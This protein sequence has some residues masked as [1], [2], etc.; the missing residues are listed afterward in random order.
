MRGFR[1]FFYKALEDAASGNPS[2]SSRIKMEYMLGRTRFPKLEINYYR[3]NP[4]E[5]AEEYLNAVP[6]L[7]IY[8]D[9]D[10]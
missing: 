6:N 8:E 5:L 1:H 3:T 4:L 9:E 10:V 7:T 2:T